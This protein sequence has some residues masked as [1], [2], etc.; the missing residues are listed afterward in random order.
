MAFDEFLLKAHIPIIQDWPV[1]GI[2]FRDI[3]PLFRNPQTARQITD[4]LVLRY[5]NSG[6]THIGALEARG[7]LLGSNLA[8]AL[9]LPL[10]LIRKAGK[11]PGKVDRIDYQYEYSQGQ[12]EIQQGSISRGDNVLLIDDLLATGQTLLAAAQLIHR[13]G[14]D[15]QEAATIIDL[16]N[17]GGRERLVEANIPVYSLLAFDD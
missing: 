3:T 10:L 2:K 6:I 8:Y 16:S 4:A 15:V 11:L 5:M 12:L 1:P 14:G 7:F 17:L 9:N 13:Q